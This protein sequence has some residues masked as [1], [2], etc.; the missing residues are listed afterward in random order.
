MNPKLIYPEESFAIRGCLFEV[1]RNKG[2]GFLEPVYQECLEIE[3]RMSSLPATAQ[4]NLKLDYKGIP[5]KSTYIPDFICYDKI[6]V[7]LKAVKE[8]TDAHRAQV[9]NYLKATGLKLAFLVNFCHHPLI[10]VERIVL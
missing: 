3:F 5:L 10:E 9:Q 4:P 7:E 1:Y 8:L 2:A 6:V